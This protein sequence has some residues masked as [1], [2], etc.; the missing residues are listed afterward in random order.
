MAYPATIP[1]IPSGI[2]KALK[3]NVD[4]RDFRPTGRPK[5]ALTVAPTAYKAA[6]EGERPERCGRLWNRPSVRHLP[7]TCQKQVWS[8]GTKAKQI[9]WNT[10]K[11]QSH[12]YLHRPFTPRGS[13]VSPCPIHYSFQHLSEL[14]VW[15]LPETPGFWPNG[16]GPPLRDRTSASVAPPTHCARSQK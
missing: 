2:W 12:S 10:F 4:K 14:G 11:T 6:V 16:E 1:P 15:L 8:E 9:E 5:V 3:A 7:V 13:Q